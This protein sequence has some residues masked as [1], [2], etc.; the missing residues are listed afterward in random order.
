MANNRLWAVCK[1]DNEAEMLIKYYPC[2]DGGWS[3]E[4]I[5]R[6]EFFKKH[7]NCPSNHGLG[8]NIQFV[9]EQDE[10]VK[11]YDFTVQ[12]KTKIYFK[13]NLIN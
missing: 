8:E 3:G 13:E 5:R 12:G 10:R 9:H 1:D 7:E 2:E 11:L 6:D 4:M